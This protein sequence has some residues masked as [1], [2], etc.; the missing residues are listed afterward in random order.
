MSVT[1]I[2]DDGAVREDDFTR[3]AIGVG[4]PER[5]DDL[6]IDPSLKDGPAV[7]R[8]RKGFSGSN[9]VGEKEGEEGC[10]G[11]ADFDHGDSPVV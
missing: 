3:E 6:L 1:R 11:D 7:Q 5:K 8:D 10:G 2:G 4:A 9:E